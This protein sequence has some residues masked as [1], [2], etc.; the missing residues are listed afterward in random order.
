MNGIVDLII[1]FVMGFSLIIGLF[2]GFVREALSV[3]SWIL[4]IWVAVTFS[5]PFADLL[6]GI[7]GSATLRSGLAFTLLFFLSLIIGM[8]V[9][10]LF[11]FVVK[12]SGLKGIDRILGMGFGLCRGALVVCVGIM[13][14][15]LTPF[16][17]EPWWTA[18]TLVPKFSPV[19]SWLQGFLPTQLPQAATIT[20]A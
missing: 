12:K 9:S 1:L 14:V 10:S 11:N 16:V 2:R 20:L 7:I 4:A 5:T 3:V 15:E 6:G 18:S 8:I 13:L 19:V 17:L